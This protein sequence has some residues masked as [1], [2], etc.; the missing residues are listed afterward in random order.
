MHSADAC[1][2]GLTPIRVI[3]NGVDFEEMESDAGTARFKLEAPRNVHIG[4]VSRL[5]PV[6]RIDLFLETASMLLRKHASVNWA[7]HIFGDG[8]LR[9]QLERYASEL[10]IG[11]AV[12]FHGHRRDISACIRGLDVLVNCS[13]HEGFPMSALEALALRTPTVAHAVGGLLAVVPREFL[14]E[15]QSAD[16]YVERVM[17]A[18]ACDAREIATRNAV[19]TLPKYSASANAA[20]V[21][22]LYEELI[23]GSERIV[24]G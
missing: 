7:F 21:R 13:D 4:S 18:V 17:R 16:G 1:R 23:S 15:N 24:A 19:E 8:P 22:A 6:K 12:T 10:Q 20:C 9:G 3:E 5:V 2:P 14:V 11:N